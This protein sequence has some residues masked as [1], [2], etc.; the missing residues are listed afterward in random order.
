M[1][2]KKQSKELLNCKYESRI[3]ELKTKLDVCEANKIK[4]CA[5][6][7]KEYNLC[8]KSMLGTGTYKG[9]RTDC[10]DYFKEIQLC[11]EEHKK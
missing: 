6:V 7:V 11:L 5:R 3:P 10:G 1:S 9:S 8:F 2:C 4:E